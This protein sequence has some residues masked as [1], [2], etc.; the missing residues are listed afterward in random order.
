MK[1]H[2]PT[3]ETKEYVLRLSTEGYTQLSIANNLEIHHETLRKYYRDQLN[4]ARKKN[5]TLYIDFLTRKAKDGDT[6]AIIYLLEKWKRNEIK[7][8]K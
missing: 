6:K 1:P 7:Q 4:E 3:R 2:K 8:K 5:K